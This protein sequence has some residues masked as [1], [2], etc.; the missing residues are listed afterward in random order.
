[1]DPCDRIASPLASQR[2][3]DHPRTLVTI[4]GCDFLRPQGLKYA[5]FLRSCGVQVEEDILRGVPHGF[6][7]A[8][9]SEL[10]KSWFERQINAFKDAFDIRETR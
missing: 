7:F 1:M 2:I 5:Q 4:A 3:P 6:T 8:L 9:N 10:V